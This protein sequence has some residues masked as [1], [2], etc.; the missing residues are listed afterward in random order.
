[1]RERFIREALDA[2]ADRQLTDTAD[3]WPAIRRSI[4]PR[5][6]RRTNARHGLATRRR[7]AIPALVLILAFSTAGAVGVAQMRQFHQWTPPRTAL[8]RAGQLHAI[9][10][11]QTIDGYTVT[12]RHAYA[13]A[14]IVLLET[15]VRDPAG[16]VVWSVLPNWQLTDE[17]GVALPQAFDS[18]TIMVDP[19]VDGQYASFDA[20]AVQTAA[21][22]LNLHLTL[23]FAIDAPSQPAVAA[24]ATIPDAGSTHATP[25]P[26]TGAATAR[27]S[28]L[29]AAFTFAVP[30]IA[31]IESN[32]Q[33]TVR[34]LDVPLTLRRIIT[35]PAETRATVCYTPPT[36]TEQDHWIVVADEDG[37][38]IPSVENRM[39]SGGTDRATGEGERCGVLHLAGQGTGSGSRE[40]RVKEVSWGP[41]GNET[42]LTGSWTFNYTLP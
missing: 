21:A 32:P 26:L 35:T 7:F 19:G 40:L 20:A 29:L 8:E 38:A 39:L 42:R 25:T 24:G 27:S 6:V 41:T 16:R 15:I 37:H 4:A 36:G 31:G 10:Q 18:G 17:H 9:D 23:T 1:M 12:L 11:V 3:P 34:A 13:D 30:F 28:T 14:N 5:P 2:Y 22:S 33:Q